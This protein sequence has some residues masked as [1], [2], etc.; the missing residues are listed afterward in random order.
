MTNGEKKIAL[1][2]VTKRETKN[3]FTL[4]LLSFGPDKMLTRA[5]SGPQASSLTCCIC[6]F[7]RKDK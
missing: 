4:K 7:I 6:K 3:N 1:R 2:T 5:V